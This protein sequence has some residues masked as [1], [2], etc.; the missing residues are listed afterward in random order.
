MISLFSTRRI[1]NCFGVTFLLVFAWKFILVLLTAQPIP[2]NDAFG[3]DGAVVNYLLNG[4]YCNPSLIIPFPFSATHLFSIYPPLYQGVLCLW[5]S[6]FGTSALAAI[7]FHLV[8]FG[9]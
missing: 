9:L 5:I 4:H 6:V 1:A 7:W 2:A 3:Y 8:F